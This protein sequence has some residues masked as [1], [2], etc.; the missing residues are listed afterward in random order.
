MGLTFP[1][2]APIDMRTVTKAKSASKNLQYRLQTPVL[3]YILIKTDRQYVHTF[4]KDLG[5]C[6]FDL[7]TGSDAFK[8]RRA[9]NLP[10]PP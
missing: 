1:K 9:R 2:T 8:G 3:F 7:I 4:F 5:R 10:R 6:L